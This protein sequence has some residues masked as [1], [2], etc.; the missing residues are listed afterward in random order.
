MELEKEGIGAGNVC[1]SLALSA[2]MRQSVGRRGRGRGYCDGHPSLEYSGVGSHR[3]NGW[4]TLS[5][6]RAMT[7]F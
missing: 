7:V 6:L 5:V 4:M 1:S 2:V 3:T